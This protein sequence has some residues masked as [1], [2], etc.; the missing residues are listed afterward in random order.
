MVGLQA[1]SGYAAE[2]QIPDGSS[3]K[4][5]FTWDSQVHNFDDITKSNAD[6]LQLKDVSL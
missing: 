6:V 5:K 2:V 3:V 1:L 4:V